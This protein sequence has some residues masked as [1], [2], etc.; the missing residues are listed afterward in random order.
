MKNENCHTL[1]L[2]FILELILHFLLFVCL[3]R[4]CAVL[5]VFNT[6]CML[7]LALLVKKVVEDSCQAADTEKIQFIAQELALLK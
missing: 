5:D 6:T 1:H 3:H 2:R 7:F 4:A